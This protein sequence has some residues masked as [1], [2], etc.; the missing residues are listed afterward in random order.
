ME[1]LSFPFFRLVDRKNLESILNEQN[2]QYSGLVDIEEAVN[3]GKIL[4][5]NIIG[6]YEVLG[7]SKI[8]DEDLKAKIY[9]I[10][11]IFKIID[12]EK[13]EIL[14][15]GKGEGRGF[16]YDDFPCSED[17]V[18]LEA[19]EDAVKN[20]LKELAKIFYRVKKENRDEG[21]IIFNY[22]TTVKGNR[23]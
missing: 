15:T 18:K 4:S 21:V 19:I 14:Y 22:F 6:I 10:F 1:L 9:T 11:L 5:A 12:V 17:E 7:T 20:S 13:G 2:F 8:R 16:L 3:F 23:K